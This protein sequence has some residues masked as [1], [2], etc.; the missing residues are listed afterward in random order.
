MD[1]F[2][3]ADE[4]GWFPFSGAT[5]PDLL[6]VLDPR[7]LKDLLE[8]GADP[9]LMAELVGLLRA[10]APVRQAA[11]WKAL[12]ATDQGAAAQ[13]AHQLKGA[14]GTLGLLRLADH[15]GR[16]EACL[17]SARWEEA[18]HLLEAF[19]AGYEEALAALLATFPEAG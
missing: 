10:D 6:P 8:M 15:V 11:L 7:P 17:R 12:E 3:G 4:A 1:P 18:R 5:L 9:G 16:M 14:L 2:R 19:P 13:E